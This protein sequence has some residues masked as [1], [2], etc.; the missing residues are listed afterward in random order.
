MFGKRTSRAGDGR[1][2]PP[3]SAKRDRKIVSLTASSGKDVKVTIGDLVDR[4]AMLGDVSG[5][6]A[7]MKRDMAAMMRSYRADAETCK[8]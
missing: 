2:D 8:P 7:L 3:G 4:S 5:R 6:V 1:I